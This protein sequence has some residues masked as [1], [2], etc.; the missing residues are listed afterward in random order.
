[1]C[2]VAVLPLPFQEQLLLNGAQGLH[3]ARPETM[4]AA[5]VKGSIS[6][7]VAFKPPD[8][9]PKARPGS[10]TE[11]LFPTVFL[12]FLASL[13][14][15]RTLPLALAFAQGVPTISIPY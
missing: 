1:M 13:L 14:A 10:R 3:K 12:K 8:D 15:S 2:F 5:R 6:G 7:F 11:K 4:Q 9:P